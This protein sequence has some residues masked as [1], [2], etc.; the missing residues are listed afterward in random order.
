MKT[1]FLI[2]KHSVIQDISTE[3]SCLSRGYNYKD[4]QLCVTDPSDFS[5]GDTYLPSKNKF[6]KT[7]ENYPKPSQLEINEKKIQIE[8]QLIIRSQAI[9]N[10]KLSGQLPID[11]KEV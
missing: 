8:M 9:E 1:F 6:I 7:P 5:I 2:D 11:F 3:L 10:L 4:C